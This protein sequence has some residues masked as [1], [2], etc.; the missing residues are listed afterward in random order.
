MHISIQNQGRSILLP[1]FAWGYPDFYEVFDIEGKI[2]DNPTFVPTLKSGDF[3]GFHP[4]KSPKLL[5]SPSPKFPQN[6]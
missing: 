6:F 1:D 3:R 2:P 4:K 5:L